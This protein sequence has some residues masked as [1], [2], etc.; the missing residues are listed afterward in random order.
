M[1]LLISECCS[2]KKCC[3]S[4]FFYFY[5]VNYKSLLSATFVGESADRYIVWCKGHYAIGIIT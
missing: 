1:V 3:Y 5:D 4:F 2:H